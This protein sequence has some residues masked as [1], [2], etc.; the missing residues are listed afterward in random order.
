MKPKV[1]IDS[2][3]LS[4]FHDRRREMNVWIDATKKWW[5]TE[6]INYDCWLSEA[7]LLE[8]QK[9]EY[10]RKKQ[11]IASALKFPVLEAIPEIELTA[12]Y[13][14]QHF[15]MPKGLIGDAIHLA[16]A[17]CYNFDFLLT[18]NC[19]HL[20]NANKRKHIRVLNARLGLSVPEIVTPLELVKEND[21]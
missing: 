12:E 5:N 3:I 16:F 10:P 1:Y 14:I 2:T 17:S 15:L 8:L 4:F 18:W 19:N 9:E 21:I 13:Y 20:A 11:V 6:M 7:V